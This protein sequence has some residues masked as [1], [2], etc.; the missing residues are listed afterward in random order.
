METDNDGDDAMGS[1]AQS[2]LSSSASSIAETIVIDIENMMWYS[3]VSPQC[4]PMVLTQL[5]E[6]DFTPITDHSHNE[7]LK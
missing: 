2:I 7:H 3:I 6:A 1:A 4:S 5:I